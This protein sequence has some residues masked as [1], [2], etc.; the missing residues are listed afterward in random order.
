MNP[1]DISKSLYIPP[2]F[3]ILECHNDNPVCQGGSIY[4]DPGFDEEIEVPVP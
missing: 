1:E 4:I 3:D 2:V